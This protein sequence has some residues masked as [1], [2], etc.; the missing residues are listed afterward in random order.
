ME[1]LPPFTLQSTLSRFY[2]TTPTAMQQLTLPLAL[3][4][5]GKV[6]ALYLDKQ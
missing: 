6:I 4:A 1:K 5:L 3:L 2:H